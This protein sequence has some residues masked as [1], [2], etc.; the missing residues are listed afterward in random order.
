MGW[1][2]TSGITSGPPGLGPGRLGG[3]FGSGTVM[4]LYYPPG[5]QTPSGPPQ[6]IG[7][8]FANCL[9][10][11]DRSVGSQTAGEEGRECHRVLRDQALDW[12]PEGPARGLADRRGQ[13]SGKWSQ[14]T[15]T[16]LGRK[17]W[18][19]HDQISEVEVSESGHAAG[20][21][22]TCGGIRS[23]ALMDWRGRVRLCCGEG[24]DPG[25]PT[26]AVLGR[27]Q[28]GT[29]PA[30]R[31]HPSTESPPGK[32]HSQYEH[33]PHRGPRDPEYRTGRPPTVHYRPF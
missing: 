22:S 7:G 10:P 12:A 4:Y 23:T 25:L 21:T 2:T 26:F 31:C 3:S 6:D 1:G 28:R 15:P 33:L 8:S 32:G 20:V 19:D 13:A 18:T 30:D 16:H 5:A 11:P 27:F 24:H 17:M 14:T 9:Q 29:A